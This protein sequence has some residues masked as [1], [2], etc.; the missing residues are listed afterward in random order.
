MAHALLSPSSAERWLTCHGSVKLTMGMEDEG[1]VYA[2]EGTAAHELAERIV[3]GHHGPSLV[4]TQA[5]NG[6]VFDAEMLR[7]AEFY[8]N[9]VFSMFGMDGLLALTEQKVAIE[10]WTLE[11]GAHGTADCIVVRPGELIVVDYKYGQGVKVDAKDNPQL[12]LYALGALRQYELSFDIAHVRMVIVQPRVGNVSEWRLSVAELEEWGSWVESSTTKIWDIVHGDEYVNEHLRPSESACR[13]C[14]AKAACPALAQEVFDTFDTVIEEGTPD[15]P[16]ARAMS[17]VGMIEDW[18]KAVRSETERR[19][20]AG[21]PVPGFKLVQGRQGAR[22]WADEQQAVEML[23]SFR[24]KT[25]EM[26]D[27]K[28]ISPTTAE[29]L[30]EAK[31]IGPR[32]WQRAQALIVRQEGKPSVAPESDSRPAIS[33]TATDDD[34]QNLV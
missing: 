27:L 16:L 10:E 29:K 12:M 34:F 23:K 20:L 7:H 22:K 26:Y 14:K 13:F 25:E 28:L 2:A 33:Q 11:P 3:K 18:C 9:I 31:V 32:Q 5:S 30:V 24:L 4:G 17:K 15:E 1:S 21:K 6:W 19:L 8:R